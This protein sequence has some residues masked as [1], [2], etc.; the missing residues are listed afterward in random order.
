M[1][2]GKDLEFLIAL[3]PVNLISEL[4]S[5][6]GLEFADIMDPIVPYKL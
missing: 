4:E 3:I 1:K 5:I 6:H 2:G